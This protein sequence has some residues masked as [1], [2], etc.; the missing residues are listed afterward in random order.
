MQFL[1]N[2]L[3]HYKGFYLT[4]ILILGNIFSLKLLLVIK[5]LINKLLL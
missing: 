5:I 2:F 4:I 3:G 1:L